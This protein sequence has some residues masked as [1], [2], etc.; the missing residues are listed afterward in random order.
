[1]IYLIN[2]NWAN[3]NSPLHWQILKARFN[4]P[5][6]LTPAHHRSTLF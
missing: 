3:C 5:N 2:S 4:T 1:M 6:C